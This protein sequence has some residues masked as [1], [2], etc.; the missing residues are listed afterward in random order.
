MHSL[1]HSERV[2]RNLIYHPVCGAFH[3]VQEGSMYA[4][5]SEPVRD[6][7][8]VHCVCVSDLRRNE[9]SFEIIIN[10]FKNS[11]CLLWQQ[12]CAAHKTGDRDIHSFCSFLPRSR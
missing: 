8:H 2:K 5:H 10:G 4:V 3:G 12:L 7:V 1:T 6:H 9:E 11:I